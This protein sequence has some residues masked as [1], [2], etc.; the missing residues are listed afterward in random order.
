MNGKE[1]SILLKAAEIEFGVEKVMQV[2]STQNLNRTELTALMQYQFKLPENH[3]LKL[4]HSVLVK[5][6]ANLLFNLPE[7]E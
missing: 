5:G 2:I 7:S 1:S 6:L 3:E 4:N